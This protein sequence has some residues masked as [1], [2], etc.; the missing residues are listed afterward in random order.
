MYLFFQ[1]IIQLHV[2]TWIFNICVQLLAAAKNIQLKISWIFQGGISL[3]A[4]QGH[5]NSFQWPDQTPTS[6]REAGG[7]VH[8]FFIIRN[9]RTE[10]PLNTREGGVL[11]SPACLSIPLISTA[12]NVQ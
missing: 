8:M 12:Q 6:K 9:S 2:T 11:K 10:E 3:Y 5:Q 4:T 7:I 1:L